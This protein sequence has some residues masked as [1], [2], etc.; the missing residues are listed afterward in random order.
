L[1]PKAAYREQNVVMVKFE[2]KSNLTIVHFCAY[3][4]NN[5]KEL[6]AVAL[7]KLSQRVKAVLDKIVGVNGK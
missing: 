3:R 2:G 5:L 1:H 7:F 4:Y 6:L